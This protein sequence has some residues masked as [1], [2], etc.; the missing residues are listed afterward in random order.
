MIDNL[1]L[2]IQ[3][4]QIEPDTLLLESIPVIYEELKDGNNKNK[5]L[6]AK[7]YYLTLKTMLQHKCFSII[8]ML[9]IIC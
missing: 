8:N 7:I 6:K 1:D 5:D 2:K 3:C 9:L 4:S